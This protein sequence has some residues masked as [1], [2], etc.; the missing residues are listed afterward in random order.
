MYSVL[1]PGYLSTFTILPTKARLHVNL[2]NL[3][4]SIKP[5]IIALQGRLTDSVQFIQESRDK[6][7]RPADIFLSRGVLGCDLVHQ[8]AGEDG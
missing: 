6:A 8:K 7:S 4:P 5:A 3:P 1:C 2:P